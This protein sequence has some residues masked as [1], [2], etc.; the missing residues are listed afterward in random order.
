MNWQTPITW[1]IVAVAIAELI[2]RCVSVVTARSTSGC[3]SGCDGC[4][5]QTAAEL[6]LVSLGIENL[7]SSSP[8]TS[9][10]LPTLQK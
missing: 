8:D 2:R 7:A 4:P 10:D 1:L 6:P 3:G 5:S 9:R